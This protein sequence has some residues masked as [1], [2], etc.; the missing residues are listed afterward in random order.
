MAWSI[1]FAGT[2]TAAIAAINAITSGSG[3][4]GEVAQVARAQTELIGAVNSFSS[5][6]QVLVNAFGNWDPTDG[7]SFTKQVAPAKVFTGVYA[8]LP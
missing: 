2:P 3:V 6:P 8:L 5:S 4:A 7:S 1:N